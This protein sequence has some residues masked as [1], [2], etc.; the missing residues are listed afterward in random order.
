MPSAVTLPLWSYY[1]G[2]IF[3]AK[4]WIKVLKD[5]ITGQL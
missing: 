3:Q 4:A 5:L 2:V 1:Q